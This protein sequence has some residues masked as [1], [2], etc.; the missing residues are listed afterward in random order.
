MRVIE[1]DDEILIK[2]A[3]GDWHLDR[4][5]GHIR[6]FAENIQGKDVVRDDLRKGPD[7]NAPLHLNEPRAGGIG[8]FGCHVARR[9][10]NWFGETNT[11]MISNQDGWGVYKESMDVNLTPPNAIV[12]HLCM[13]YDPWS[14]LFAIARRY[15]IAETYITLN[16]TVTELGDDKRVYIKEPK[17]TAGICPPNGVS[18]GSATHYSS[19]GVR[20]AHKEM[21]S[22]AE[23]WKGTW[24]IRAP[25]RFRLHFSHA[26]TLGFHVVGDMQGFEQWV[27][28]AE[29][30]PKFQSVCP[31]YCMQGPP[32]GKL[33]R[34]WEVAK[35]KDEPDIGFMLH[36]WEGGAGASDCLCCARQ[37][38]RFTC[39]VR[40]ALSFG[41]GFHSVEWAHAKHR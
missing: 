19:N 12:T 37:T 22:M 38:K 13:L 3:M 4:Q 31:P 29:T 40:L 16:F 10:S 28:D 34:A 39:R 1:R 23:P 30:R 9:D 27:D 20:L 36:A 41:P 8:S 18:Y 25:N 26:A 14:P 15:F 32:Y 21:T 33:T 17:V 5:R 35:R 6:R 24:Q 7:P 2:N 11:R